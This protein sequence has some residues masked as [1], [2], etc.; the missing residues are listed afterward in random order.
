MADCAGTSQWWHPSVHG[1]RRP[2]LLARNEMKRAIRDWFENQGFVEV[3]TA[4]LQVSPGNETHIHA[5]QTDVVRPDE[6]ATAAYL[7]TS[8]EF[9]CK[10]LL[11]A[12]EP[13]LF[14]FAPVFRNRE[15]GRL[16]AP[17]FTMLEWYRA[18][19]PFERL[20]AD[21]EA[22]VQ[23]AAQAV[24]ASRFRFGAATCPSDMATRRISVADAFAQFAEIDLDA[25][26]SDGAGREAFGALALRAGVRVAD[27][28]TWSDIFSRVL[29]EKIEPRLGLD[30]PVLLTHY[31][32][33]E[34]ALARLDPD[35]HRFAQRAELYIC[36]V[37]VA[38]G[39]VELTDANEQRT[40]FERAMAE[41]ERIY[42]DRYP[43]DE[44]FLAALEIMP[45]AI[46]C[47][48]GFDRLV[49]LATGAPG[50]AQVMWTPH[51]PFGS[52]L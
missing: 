26:L 5:F 38:N 34:A 10:K 17:E 32:A 46:G 16:H 42:G 40:R 4:C 50:V 19:E 22:I 14:A 6:S 24:S 35:D 23:A 45:T 51:G 52:D 30:C 21:C 9:A 37:E 11:A 25:H 36:G 48:L 29:T 7:H 47:A 18:H 49:M 31:P 43:I 39:F 15:R 44:E 27:D 2:I 28:D 1:D 20:L 3:D 13:S 8:P 12:G 33:S 41:R